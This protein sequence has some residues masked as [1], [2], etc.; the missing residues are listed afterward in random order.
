MS[1][2]AAV[3]SE[4]IALYRRFHDAPLLPL[5]K[6]VFDMIDEHDRQAVDLGALL[7][8]DQA[9]LT[10]QTRLARA[11]LE[12]SGIDLVLDAIRF[13]DRLEN[14][15]IVIVGEGCLDA[16][17]LRGKAAVVTARRAAKRDITVLA[18]CG[19][20]GEGWKETLAINGGPIQA[21]VSLVEQ[22][23]EAKAI[24]DPVTCLQEA[25]RELLDAQ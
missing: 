6:T 23:G 1:T 19:R 17:S 3:R 22:F 21:A 18:I 11:A 14:V 15:D 8:P 7:P 4:A 12:A 2:D 16:Q 20:L 5:T 13:D 10:R 24:N 9:W 25:T